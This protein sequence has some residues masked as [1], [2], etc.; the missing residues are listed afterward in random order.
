MRSVIMRIWSF[1]I[2]WD[3]FSRSRIQKYIGSVRGF[4]FLGKHPLFR[5]WNPQS[6]PVSR[7]QEED[8][9]LLT[10]PSTK[11]MW[12]SW[13]WNRN[14]STRP[15]PQSPNA[16]ISKL[17]PSTKVNIH[18]FPEMSPFSS[19]T[20]SLLRFLRAYWGKG[21]QLFLLFRVRWMPW[22]RRKSSVAPWALIPKLE[23][24]TSQRR[25]TERSRGYSLNPQ[26]SF[27]TRWSRSKTSKWNMSNSRYSSTFRSVKTKELRSASSKVTMVP[28]AAG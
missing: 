9:S 10:I 14:W 2:E 5:W 24:S 23:W 27:M 22:V 13:I 16:H 1:M 28:S 21:A 6:V 26:P 11:S 18:S 7:S 25:S 15:F 12:E 3:R 19:T 20:A 17:K 8:R 4:L